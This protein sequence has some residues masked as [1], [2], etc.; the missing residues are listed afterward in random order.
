MTT[1][2]DGDDRAELL[3]FASHLTTAAHDETQVEVN[4]RALA[5]WVAAGGSPSDAERRMA[6]LR[7]VVANLVRL[8]K[9]PR[10]D[11]EE[12]TGKAACFYVF[13]G[14][15]PALVADPA[16][17]QLPPAVLWPFATPDGGTE[18]IEVALS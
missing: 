17:I 5:A 1:S 13:L 4:A 8:D 10:D 15:D 7:Q 6:A 3:R 14:G 12:L 16:A 9:M 2:I 18:Y 11:V